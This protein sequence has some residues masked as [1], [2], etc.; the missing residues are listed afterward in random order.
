M[1]TE[2]VTQEFAAQ[3][4]LCEVN[5]WIDMYAAAPPDFERQLG[6]EIIRAG[7]IVLTRCKAIPFI[8][9][10]C[11]MNLGIMEAATERQLDDLLSRYRHAGVERPMVL[12]Y[13][14]LPAG[15]VA[16]VVSHKGPSGPGRMGSH[17]SP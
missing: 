10:N 4:E 13:P 5:A 3:L 2:T 12:P 16:G 7:D 8:H 9:F 15:G 14:A 11:V 1:L 6:T 17:L